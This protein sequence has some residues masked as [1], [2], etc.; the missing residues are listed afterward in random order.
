[1]SPTSQLEGRRCRK[2]KRKKEKR[3]EE[4]GEKSVT[5][6]KTKPKISPKFGTGGLGVPLR[7]VEQVDPVPE[8]RGDQPVGDCWQAEGEVVLQVGEVCLGNLLPQVG[9][10]GREGSRVLQQF[11]G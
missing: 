10:T 5:K 4:E 9:A 1:M 6:R 2:R 11:R 8:Q 3:K 7:V